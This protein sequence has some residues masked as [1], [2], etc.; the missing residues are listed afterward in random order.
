MPEE[1]R[2]IRAT[3]SCSYRWLWTIQYGCWVLN[4]GPLQELCA[5]WTINHLSTPLFI[6]LKSQCQS[7]WTLL[8]VERLSQH[9]RQCCLWEREKRGRKCAPHVFPEPSRCDRH[10]SQGDVIGFLFSFCDAAICLPDHIYYSYSHYMPRTVVSRFRTLPNFRWQVYVSSL[11]L[12]LFYT[13]FPW[14][15]KFCSW[16]QQE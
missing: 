5:F 14:K 12:G 3:Q 2:G 16:N 9:L 10:I 1:A 8:R 7:W 6:F 13:S 15:Y 4:S 11:T